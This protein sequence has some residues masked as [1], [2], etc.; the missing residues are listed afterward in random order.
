MSTTHSSSVNRPYG[1][2]RVCRAWEIARSTFYDW[3]KRRTVNA[4]LARRGPKPLVSDDELEQHIRAI[5]GALEENHGIQGEGYRK[6]HARLRAQG[7]RTTRRRVLRVM[8]ENALLSPTRVGKPRGP[9]NHDGRITTDQPDVMW[10]TD[11]TRT[12]TLEEGLAWVFAAVDHCTGE[13]VGIHAS[14]SGS[15]Y[16]ALEPVHQGVRARFGPIDKDVAS[17][18]SLRHDHGTQYTSGA[19]QDQIE[20][21][22][23]ESSPSFVRTPEGN[24]VAERFFRTLK[25]QLLWVRD[26]HG[27]EELRLALLDF[28]RTYNDSW[29]LARHSYRT[30]NQVRAVLTAAA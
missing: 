19:F 22:G 3:R 10:G 30:P 27:I 2:V 28:Q 6:T 8:R 11:A 21:L 25:E 16:E 20:F 29:I 12:A 24:G 5:H 1:V 4:P 7:I 9:R 23:I 26:F 15:R 18:L 17:G 13:I 14:E